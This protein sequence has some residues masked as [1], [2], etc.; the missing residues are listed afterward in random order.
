MSEDESA[1]VTE[2]DGKVGHI[3]LNRPE[4]MN[5]ITVELGR[6]LDHALRR[7]AGITS[8]IVIRGAGGN[9]SVG[10]DFNELERLRAAGPEALAPLFD[11][12]ARA[13]AT[14]GEL[15][16]PV[17]AAVEGYAMAGGFEL[18]QS[19]DI[20]LVRSDARLADNHVNF[21]QVPGGGG[22]VRL[23]RL[24]GLP[25][26][27]GHLLS[28]ERLTGAQAV[29]WGIA[30]RDFEPGEFESGIAEFA[31]RLATKAPAAL[32]GIKS[33]VR[34]GVELPLDRALLRERDAVIAHVSGADAAAGIAGFTTRE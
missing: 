5:A 23:P 7:L 19:C 11:N 20:A 21:G 29:A 25:R 13:C 28:G 12:F 27:L 24:A 18:M 33:L 8:V 16:V 1:V 30:Y 32:A 6:R 34:A 9:F 22:S 26:A 3:L 2:I 4:A 10:G 14:I 15:P 31:A 17:V